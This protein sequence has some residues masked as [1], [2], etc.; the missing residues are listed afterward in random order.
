MWLLPISS[1]TLR[2]S[3]QGAQRALYGLSAVSDQMPNEQDNT[4]IVAIVI[5]L[6]A[7]FVTTAQLL[8]ALFGTAEGY[9]RCQSSV[10]GGWAKKTRRKWRWSEFR[11]ETIFTTP[12]IH[13]AV[14]AK[15]DLGQHAA[16]IE[17]DAI[18]RRQTHCEGLYLSSTE[19]NQN[20][21]EIVDDLVGWLSLLDMIHRLQSSYFL[22]ASNQLS[23]RFGAQISLGTA[24]T[25]TCP[26]VNFR[27]RSWDFMPPEIVRPFATSNVG[28]IIALA[29]RLGMRWKD[30]RP[31]DG[32]MR[33]EGNSQSI[34]STSV[35]GF[36][37]L[38]QYSFDR[39]TLGKLKRTSVFQRT[40]T[41][42]S[43]EADMLGFQIVP[44]SRDLYLPNF[45]F[46][47]NPS[48]ST[49]ARLPMKQL[50]VN[51]EIQ[52]MYDDYVR[53][54]LSLHGLSDLVA[55]VTPFLPLPGSTVV[56]IFSPYPD[57]HDSPTNWWE[58]FVLYHARLLKYM[59]EQRKTGDR[60]EQMEWVLER[61]EYMRRTY[62]WN[63]CP[64]W[65]AES[66][67]KE[68]KNGRSIKFLN[69]LR[70]IWSATTTYFKAL[71]Q[72]VQSSMKHF[73]YIDLVGAHIAQAV[74]YPDLA[75]ANIKAGTNRRYELGAGRSKRVAEGMHIYVDQIPKVVDFMKN[76]GFYDESVVREAW[77]T[78]ILRAMCWH[79][80]VAF[81]EIPL[82]NT[83]PS[84]FHGSRT[85]VY[86]A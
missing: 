38:L 61:F 78:L 31:D 25:M 76:K 54:S 70:S 11:F 29:H 49:V 45:V 1:A 77:W 85:P 58:G 41:I 71:D 36:G 16:F 67:N 48:G 40:L 50:G 44:G 12:E 73:H 27:T 18:S 26:A 35:R 65:E 55:M 86:I 81:L 52:D 23:S 59:E 5:A 43:R 69:D 8:Q 21:L 30:I 28:D 10:I 24:E 82:G 79:R 80:S 64:S 6:I 53:R 57:V 2:S 39:G 46:D 22:I 63:Q 34:T 56:Q 83:V 60:S 32:V 66:A 42:P 19:P 72:P 4:A 84:S 17:G 37:L 3:S 13:L 14:M 33:A 74:Y 75:E 9:R 68:I 7:F 62:P 20:D 15:P 51:R 47:K